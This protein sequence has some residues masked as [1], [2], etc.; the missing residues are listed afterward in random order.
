MKKKVNPWAVCTAKFGRDSKKY[1]ECVM[2]IKR[3]QGIEESLNMIERAIVNSI[4]NKLNEAKARST[5]DPQGGPARKMPSTN[6]RSV[7]APDFGN[8]NKVNQARTASPGRFQVMPGGKA[9]V[10]PTPKLKPS[11]RPGAFMSVAAGEMYSSLMKQAD[12]KWKTWSEISAEH[13]A[14]KAS[15]KMTNTVASPVAKST[16]NKSTTSG[17][18]KTQRTAPRKGSESGKDCIPQEVAQDPNFSRGK[19]HWVNKPICKADESLEIK[20]IEGFGNFLMANGYEP[21]N[22]SDRPK[23]PRGNFLWRNVKSAMKAPVRGLG[24]MWL[25]QIGSVPIVGGLANLA[26]KKF[27]DEPEER[28]N[29]E[30]NIYAKKLARWKEEQKQEKIKNKE[31]EKLKRQRQKEEEKA[32]KAAQKP[33]EP[34]DHDEDRDSLISKATDSTQLFGNKIVERFSVFLNELSVET[35]KSYRAKAMAQ[36]PATTPMKREKGISKASGKIAR[37]ASGRNTRRSVTGSKSKGNE[38]YI[39][40]GKAGPS[41]PPMSKKQ[42]DGTRGTGRE[43]GT[44]DAHQ[45]AFDRLVTGLSQ[46]R[47]RK[48]R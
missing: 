48:K 29:K 38:A 13:E 16:T 45:A 39:K 9:S 4:N 34:L 30:D 40:R 17:T 15:S 1:E 20:I 23:H 12:P 36:D 8:L 22:E 21:I 5:Q 6:L 31:Q 32:R 14:K 2:A 44:A 47:G 19:G 28:E 26:R 18:M 11:F 37:N 10:A 3:E 24:K 27:I 41:K 25:N 42:I 35:L 43:G 33:L 7:D 46:G